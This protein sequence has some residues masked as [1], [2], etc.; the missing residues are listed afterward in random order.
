MHHKHAK[1]DIFEKQERDVV[2]ALR[3]KEEQEEEDVI[4][5]T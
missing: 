4:Q 5:K 2:E 1:K 3:Q